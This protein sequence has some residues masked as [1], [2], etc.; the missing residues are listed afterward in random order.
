M[1]TKWMR[2]GHSESTSKIFVSSNVGMLSMNMNKKNQNQVSA[3]K[4]NTGIA[5]HPPPIMQVYLQRPP[6]QRNTVFK[7]WLGKVEV[8][9]T[10]TSMLPVSSLSLLGMAPCGLTVRP[11][12]FD[13]N[14][15]QSWQCGRTVQARLLRRSSPL[16]KDRSPVKSPANDKSHPTSMFSQVFGTHHMSYISMPSILMWSSRSAKADTKVNTYIYKLPTNS[17]I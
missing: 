7:A 11:V 3:I 13:S 17:T 6:K 15:L 1:S 4:T 2:T 5:P 12:I 16:C 10:S 14:H 8:S 9:C